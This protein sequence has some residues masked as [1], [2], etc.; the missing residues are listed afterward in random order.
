MTY[1]QLPS[2]LMQRGQD[3]A[4]TAEHLLHLIT[5]AISNHPRSLQ[6][7][8]GPS[9]IGHPCARR[10]G[11]RMLGKG[12]RPGEV[13]WKATVGTALHAWLE[14]VLDGANSNYEQ[15]T[16]SGQ[17][18]FYIE[19][20]V[21]VGDIAGVPI[22]GS[23]DVYDRAT[24]TVVDWKSVG[25]T[26]LAKYRRFGPGEQYRI[27]A[28]LYGRG[29]RARGVPVDYVMVVFLPRNGELAET[30]TWWEAYDEQVALDALQRATG[31]ALATQALGTGALP[32]LATADAFCH[33]CPYFLAHS[34]VPAAGCPGHVGRRTRRDP[35]ESLIA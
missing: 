21:T 34:T 9:E 35:I 5:D 22:E 18:R 15:R 31:I 2:D 6:K 20:R 33:K 24:A 7:Q 28:H 13:N 1:H 16:Q 27:Q 12:E 8:I 25:P 29:W 11:Y 26:Q 10:I 4:H 32:H 14:G 3:P 19:Q 30:Y 23:C 17:E